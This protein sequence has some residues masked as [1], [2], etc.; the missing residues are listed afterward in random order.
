M[1]YL[2]QLRAEHAAALLLSTDEAS[3]YHRARGQ[4]QEVV[5]WL[6]GVCFRTVRTIRTAPGH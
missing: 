5:E 6:D 2:A 3:H 1:A 4:L